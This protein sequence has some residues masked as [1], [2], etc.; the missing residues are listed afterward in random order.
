MPRISLV[1]DRADRTYVAG[2]PVTGSVEVDLA[3][4]WPDAR[5]VLARLWRA[6][7]HAE[8]DTGEA[9]EVVLFEGTRPPGRTSHPIAC[10]APWGPV[11]AGRTGSPARC[12]SP[13]GSWRREER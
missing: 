8:T 5:L 6:T 10:D 4:A 11:T 9:V 12:A 13:T 3:E 7:G 1:L 2:A